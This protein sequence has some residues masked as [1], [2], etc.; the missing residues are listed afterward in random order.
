M[1]TGLNARAVSTRVDLIRSHRERLLW[2]RA[3]ALCVLHAELPDP[4]RRT[5]HR[6]VR[7]CPRR[8]AARAI[9]RAQ[10]ARGA[11]HRG[12][13]VPSVGARGRVVA[14]GRWT[15]ARGAS[16]GRVPPL[17]RRVVLT[18]APRPIDHR[19]RRIRRGAAPHRV[20]GL[21]A[22]LW[23]A[24]TERWRRRHVVARRWPLLGVMLLRFRRTSLVGAA[25]P[26]FSSRTR[27][28][29]SCVSWRRPC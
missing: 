21:G 25:P 4:P 6:G 1:M 17:S 26:Y 15:R 8:C 10:P 24:A 5:D 11:N 2:W 19:D 20:R 27:C 22:V 28:S 12:G 14:A 9:P 16:H 3:R 23:L 13:H 29:L 18:P 7:M